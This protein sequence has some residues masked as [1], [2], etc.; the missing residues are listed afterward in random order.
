MLWT[1]LL[2]NALMFVVELTAGLLAESTGL[3]ADALDML[4]DSAVYGIALYA[5]GHALAAKV[6]AA[7]ISGVLQMFLALTVAVDVSRRV[8]LG[9]DP[10]PDWMMTIGLLAL[11]ANLVC[12]LLI[13][14]QRQGE[15]HMRASWVFTRNDVIANLGIIFS[16]VLVG[17]LDSRF[18]DLIIGTLITLLVFRGGVSIVREAR[19]EQKPAK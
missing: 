6:R 12:A 2:V 10:Q 4:A 15:I 17:W 14:R 11:S 8:I 3:V 9:S 13:Y 19:A 7:M 5:T 18:P 16:A 1:L